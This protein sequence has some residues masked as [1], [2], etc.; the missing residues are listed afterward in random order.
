MLIFS[1]CIEMMFTEL[2]FEKRFEAVKATGL[3]HAEFWNWTS[4]DLNEI[5]ISAE[6]SAVQITSMCIGSQ[7][8]MLAAEF[9]EKALLSPGSGEVLV[10]VVEES[11]AAAKFLGVPSLII[12][13][14]QERSDCSHAIQHENVVKALRMAAPLLEQSG[15]SAVLEPL[16][17][18]CDHKGYFLSSGYEAFD[19][20]REVGSPKIKVLFDIYHQQITE[21]NLIPNICS[22][23]DLIGHF[24]VAD[25]PGRHEPGTG[26]INYKN[27]FTVL[28]K[29]NYQGCIGLEYSPSIDAAKALRNTVSLANIY[30]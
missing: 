2:P 10:K 1:P 15:I 17:V 13:T 27:I 14:G 5:K 29:L 7:D 16:N 26:E 11:I 12:T 18:L 22:N 4:R 30:L 24:H 21:G 3:N 6:K 19:I 8:S 28:D 9:G 23:I 20:I 25:N